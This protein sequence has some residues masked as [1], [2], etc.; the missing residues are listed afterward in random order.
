M[1]MFDHDSIYYDLCSLWHK[2]E[3]M[4]VDPFIKST[5][6]SELQGAFLDGYG[7]AIDID[8]P[9]FKAIQVRRK[10]TKML[11]IASSDTYLLHRRI[12]DRKLYNQHFDWL[13]MECDA[14]LGS[15]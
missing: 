11:E 6:V 13:V 9:I 4:K 3:T 15:A 10:V 7:K 5:T 14:V 2:L 8:S 12:M 1:T